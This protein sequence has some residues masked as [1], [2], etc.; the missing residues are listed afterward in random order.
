MNPYDFDVIVVGGGPAGLSAAIRTRWAKRY[1]AVACS[2]LLIEAAH[3]GGLA[4]WRGC[5]FAGPSW[6]IDREDILGRFQKDMNALHIPVHSGRVE[7]ILT[8]GDI[9]TVITDD[10]T[11]FNAL[12]VI[13]ATGIKS[14]TNER[15][16]LGRGL[17]VTSMGYEAIVEKIQ[18]FCGRPGSERLVFIGSPKLRNLIPLI[19]QI[20]PAGIQPIFIIEENGDSH[21]DV[22]RGWVERFHGETHLDGIDVKTVTG[23]RTIRCDAA[24]L[25]FNSYEIAPSCPIFAPYYLFPPLFSSWRR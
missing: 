17:D 9:K 16:Y 3:L 21:G 25:D 5:L 20:A 10:G 8:E 12:C 15:D 11:K 2:T 4:S 24:L 22:V 18:E 19:R 7:T 23:S 6:Q 13:I 14:L 1:K